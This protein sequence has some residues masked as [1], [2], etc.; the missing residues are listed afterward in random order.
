MIS[1]EN[2]EKRINNIEKRNFRVEADKAWGR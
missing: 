1:L 2:L